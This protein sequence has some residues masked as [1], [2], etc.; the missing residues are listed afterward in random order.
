[1]NR[2]VVIQK[3]ETKAKRKIVISDIHG[4]LDLYLKLL[5]QISYKPN[6]DC[7]IL[8]GDLIE[9]GKRNLDT[10]II[11]CTKYKMKMYIVSWE[12]VI[13]LRRMFFIRIA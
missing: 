1:M 12:I 5:D 6:E 7:L 4:N 10:C 13:L 2:S 8:L 11:L 9:K 3:L